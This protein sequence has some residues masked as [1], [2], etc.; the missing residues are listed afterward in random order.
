MEKLKKKLVRKQV[1]S[2]LLIAVVIA[3][4]AITIF[5]S[6]NRQTIFSRADK[7]GGTCDPGDGFKGCGPDGCNDWEICDNGACLDTTNGGRQPS[8]AD[9]CGGKVVDPSACECHGEGC[10][11]DRWCGNDCKWYKDLNYK[12]ASP[13]EV[14]AVPTVVPATQVPPPTQPP[15]LTTFDPPARYIPTPTMR[16]REG[17]NE[18]KPTIPHDK[19]EA[20]YDR[21][22]PTPTPYQYKYNSPTS[23]PTPTPTPYKV[24]VSRTQTIRCLSCTGMALWPPPVAMILLPACLAQNCIEVVEF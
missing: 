5:F 10:H 20:K 13:T 12:C 3:V 15:T 19:R 9:S 8:S 7:K 23:I 17:M 2:L 4:S 21:I 14:P 11:G 16:V 1:I 22:S 18:P 6:N 24:K